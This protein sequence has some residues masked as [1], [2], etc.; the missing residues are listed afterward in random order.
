MY[1]F[2]LIFK[3]NS[4]DEIQGGKDDKNEIEKILVEHA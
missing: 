3:F 4:D 1:L 2:L